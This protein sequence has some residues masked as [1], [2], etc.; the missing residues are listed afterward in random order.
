MIKESKGFFLEMIPKE[1]KT[2]SMF[3]RIRFEGTKFYNH[4]GRSNA[5]IH[6]T[7]NSK[8]EVVDCEFIENYS[9]DRG[10]II[11]SEF[12]NSNVLVVNTR[13][14]RNSGFQGGIFFV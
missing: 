5:M 12:N 7:Q 10:G 4:T 2:L 3:Q 13:F 14:L 6:V 11:Y 9:F 1:M 8:L